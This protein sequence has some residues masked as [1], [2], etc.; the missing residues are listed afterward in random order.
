MWRASLGHGENAASAKPGPDAPEPLPTQLHCDPK[1]I[2]AMTKIYGLT[3]NGT[4]AQKIE[5]SFNVNRKPGGY[6]VKYNEMTNQSGKQTIT[7]QPETFAM[8]HVHGQNAGRMGWKLSDRNT[9]Y[10]PGPGDIEN[11]KR[12]GRVEWFVASPVGLGYFNPRTMTSSI[13]LRPGTEW[14]QQCRAT[15]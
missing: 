11:A 15:R 5:A 6:D 9:V 1:I 13:L 10:E 12:I 8:F 14:G 7:L 2:Q 4:N 3:S